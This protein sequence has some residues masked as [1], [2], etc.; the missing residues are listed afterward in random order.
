MWASSA[1]ITE[2]KRRQ[3]LTTDEVR[4]ST[5][6]VRHTFVIKTVFDPRTEEDIS[7]TEAVY[8]G[9]ID[10]A[11]GAFNIK[12]SVL[13]FMQFHEVSVIKICSA[14]RPILKTLCLPVGF[15]LIYEWLRR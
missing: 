1:D 7:L 3:Q 13:Y 10:Q 2:V 9:I 6:E 4:Q 14:M 11:A 5:E 15:M 12:F 8:A